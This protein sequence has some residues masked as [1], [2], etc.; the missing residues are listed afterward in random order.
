MRQQTSLL[1]R[2]SFVPLPWDRTLKPRRLLHL[3]S[4]LAH[5]AA[6]ILNR[7]PVWDIIH[8]THF[9]TPVSSPCLHFF[10]FFFSLP[11]GSFRLFPSHP[12][13]RQSFRLYSCA[14]HNPADNSSVLREGTDDGVR[15]KQLND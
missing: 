3:L 13:S 12:H 6:C 2:S 14:T 11:S 10:F 1:F 9:R 15:L 7:F 8:K 5:A 4:A